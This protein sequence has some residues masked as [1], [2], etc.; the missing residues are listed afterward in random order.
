MAEFTPMMQQYFKIKSLYQD[1]ILFYR[2][3]DFYEMFFEDAKVASR[4][5]ELVLTG[6]DCGQAERAPMCGVPFHAAD[7]YIARLVAKGYKVAV[8]EQTEDPAAAKGIV[9][10]DV[11]RVVTPGTVTESIMLD[12]TKNNYLACI[13]YAKDAVGMSFCDVSTGELTVSEVTGR[14]AAAKTVN[15]L[16]R[17][18]P[19]ELLFNEAASDSKTL[20]EYVTR[21]TD[22]VASVQE[23]DRFEFSSCVK[24]V[25]EHFGKSVAQLGMD[26]LPHATAALGC[27]LNYLYETQKNSLSN[28][29]GINIYRE[30][31]YL[32][33]NA[34]TRRN[35]EL[36]E[37]ERRREKKGSLL[38]VLDKTKTAMG[39]RMLRAWV[40]QPLISVSA[41][42]YRQNAVEE[43]YCAN[44][45]RSE[46]AEAFAG[47]NDLERI[48]TRVA[49]GSANA[50][51]LRSL[52][53]S[54]ALLPGIKALLAPCGAN[55]IKDLCA[56]IDTLED[57]RALIDGAI[58]ED[59]PFS[60]REGG[61][62]RA[63]YHA[64]LDELREIVNGGRDFLAKI[65][66]EEQEKTGIKKLKIGYNKVFG[67]YIEVLNSFK[68]LVPDSYI[69]KQTLTNAE[70]YITPE[71]KELESRV[72]GAQER[73]VRLEY[74]LFTAVRE[75]VAD[76][77]MRIRL[78]GTCI[79][80]LDALCSLAETAVRNGYVRPLVDDSDTIDI[81][82]GRHPVVEQFTDGAPF[83][84]NDTLLD[85]RDNR[86]AIITGPNMAGK[87]TYMR[88]TA[89][90]VLMAQMGSF[91]P[92]A[93]ASIGIVDSIF[94]RV[95]ASDDLVGGQSTFMT[96]MSEVAAILSSATAKSL[97][98]LDEIGRGTSTY[99][100]MSIAR[101]VLEYVTDKKKI[102][103]KTMFATHY[104]ELTELEGKIEGVKNYNTS[105]KKRGDDITF[106][107]R[108]VRGCADGSYGIEV[109]K[110]SGVPN[111][112]VNRA[113]VILKELEETGLVTEKPAP[114]AAKAKEEPAN[115]M[116]M[117]LFGSMNDRLLEEIKALDVNT[118]T[119]LEALTKLYDIKKRI[120]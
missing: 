72:L 113:K 62:I 82:D 81:K 16:A 75:K 27:L 57:I 100:G 117:G 101:A 12:E 34:V 80:R 74:E 90:I 44:E 96:E 50:K 28:I 21:K 99:D 97:I 67:Y 116:Q 31:K 107:R 85:G 25:E 39:K 54:L 29:T 2:L 118:L 10:R 69:R 91:V 76:A 95:G 55:M 9:T 98:I 93:G 65:E 5:L 32:A 49:Y 119:P 108:I 45:L 87:S 30:E 61:M 42:V 110:L 71:L 43:L 92:A 89:I 23:D 104:H 46:L 105:V 52:S 102:G 88:Q 115:E 94:T 24:T 63:G 41:I 13:C 19:T 58:V 47:V 7:T 3:G 64:E 79:A 18:G 51:E 77:Q 17:F 60:V 70:R 33:M 8:C 112:V 38:W 111:S 68:E 1:A 83:V 73:I 78:T 53:Q 84:P 106:L 4:E 36:T 59:P 120:V 35:L 109:A 103:A 22:I 114:A 6:R 86:T 11:I 15:S 26:A 56:D 66:R 40:E 20:R 48:A 14:D 37:T